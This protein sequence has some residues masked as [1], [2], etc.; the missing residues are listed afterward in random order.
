MNMGTYPIT[1]SATTCNGPVDVTQIAVWTSTNTTV[2]TVTDG[3]FTLVE[4]VRQVSRPTV[5]SITSPTT[6]LNVTN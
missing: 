1:A 6:T 3:T 2:A 5:G 4:S